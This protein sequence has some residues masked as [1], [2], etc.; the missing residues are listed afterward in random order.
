M[1]ELTVPTVD[2]S[3]LGQLPQVI[4]QN[5]ADALRRQTLANLGQ[6]GQ[7]DAETLLRSGDLSL[8]QLG[9]SLRNR[10]E[11]QAR[12][13]AQDAR[14]AANDKFTHSLQLQQLALSKRAADRADDPTPTNFVRDPNAPGGYRPVGPADPAY[15][16]SIAAAK[17][18]AAAS[19]PPKGFIQQPDGSLAPRVGGPTDPAY[20][21][22]VDA[23]KARAKGD[24]PTIIG[25][26]SSVIV[27]NKA[28]DGPVFI[29]KVA[30]GGLSQ[31][32][33]DIRAAQWNNGDYEGATKNV[34]RG[35]QGGAT[36]EAIANRA[37]ER[38]IEQGYSP[39]QAAA[40]T[41]Q[42]MQKFRASGIGQNTE[43]RTSAS[44]EANLNLV[45]KATEAAIPAALEQ[46]EKVARTGWVPLNKIIQG[47]QVM[48]SDPELRKFGM[49]NLQLAEHWARA[50]NPTGVMR[51]SDRDLALHFLST[52]DSK[53][54][55]KQVVGQLKT[56]IVR[57]RD[58][59]KGGHSDPAAEA[60][61]GLKAKYGLD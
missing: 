9:I 5:R 7:A 12:Q 21:A 49:A 20:L 48:T 17:A 4:Q 33:L 54:T 29:N 1:A 40:A 61:A 59:I 42:N 24:V 36:L 37:A 25:A 15:I 31:D 13:A 3:S 19:S 6:G 50:M 14:L 32:A 60:N 27:P 2:F 23:E 11:D 52:A 57:E 46:S 56:Q 47:G 38:L 22:R 43:S 30:G 34:G 10:Q 53:D 55:Y 28:A 26:G 8:A 44:R 35:A 18:R 51:E 39:E 41:S 45:L 16:E 58:A